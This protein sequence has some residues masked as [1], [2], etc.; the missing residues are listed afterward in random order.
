[1]ST[2][3]ST[4][5]H[6]KSPLLSSD[7]SKTVFEHV[8]PSQKS[9]ALA[10]VQS[11]SYKNNNNNKHKATD[12]NY[13][14]HEKPSRNVI[15]NSVT[16]KTTRNVTINTTHDYLDTEE[17]PKN[18]FKTKAKNRNKSTLSLHIE[19]YE[20]S[21][22]SPKSQNQNS[23]GFSPL[24]PLRHIGKEPAVAEIMP[25]KS[26]QRLLNLNRSSSI[27][28]ATS[29]TSSS[30]TKID[31]TY[32]TIQGGA[33]HGKDGATIAYTVTND[34]RN[35]QLNTNDGHHLHLEFNKKH[36]YLILN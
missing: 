12:F 36:A 35:Y 21:I 29:L 3:K 33:G 25:F 1:M 24:E 18:R 23:S 20:K 6:Q 13:E 15:I 26:S 31:G 27:T 7:D 10:S 5:N 32:G 11:K 30:S 4:K 28:T 14:N 8:N 2:K 16:E 19:D 9:K 17:P 34:G 22:Q